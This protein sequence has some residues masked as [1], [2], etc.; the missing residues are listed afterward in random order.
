MRLHWAWYALAI[1]AGVY[2]MIAVCFEAVVRQTIAPA[3]QPAAEPRFHPVRKAPV[4]PRVW[5]PPLE[6]PP[7]QGAGPKEGGRAGE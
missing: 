1:L 4:P 3:R 6:P 5:V 2:R 7:L